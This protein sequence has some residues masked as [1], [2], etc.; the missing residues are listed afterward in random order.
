MLQSYKNLNGFTVLQGYKTFND[1]TTLGI[2]LEFQM[3][4]ELWNDF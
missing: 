2:P 4:I 1:L 3:V